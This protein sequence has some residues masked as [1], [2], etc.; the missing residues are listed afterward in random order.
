MTL[1]LGTEE[2]SDVRLASAYY[3]SFQSFIAHGNEA[4]AEIVAERAY[5]AR[6]CREGEDGLETLQMQ[7]PAQIS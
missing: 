2:I 6:L 5:V 1:L 3:D 4:S 7:T